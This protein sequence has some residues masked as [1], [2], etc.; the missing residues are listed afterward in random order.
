MKLENKENG[1]AATELWKNPD[2][3]V[4][5]NTPV[6]KYG[7]LFGISEGNDIFCI[8]ARDGKSAWTA[9]SGKASNEDSGG[10]RGRRRGGY[11]TIVDAGSVLLALTPAAELLVFQPTEKA[12]TELARIKVAETPTYASPVPSGNRLFVKDQDS[13]TLWT[14]P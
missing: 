7:L 3:S 12:Y 13:V 2:N 5:F 1:V 6:L 9:P 11:G 14:V 4:M 8:N 10:G